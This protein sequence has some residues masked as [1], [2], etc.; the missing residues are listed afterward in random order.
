MAVIN[1]AT[2]IQIKRYNSNTWNN[3][4]FPRTAVSLLVKSV[5]DDTPFLDSGGKIQKM[6]LPD[7]L[8]GQL[9]YGGTVTADGLATLSTNA[10]TKLGITDNEIELGG[11]T[12]G[13]YSASV[14][15]GL[16]FIAS[17]Y[18]DEDDWSDTVGIEDLA[19]GD[20]VIATAS[21][22]NKID[23]T[24]AVTSVAGRTGAITLGIS[25]I[26]NLSATLDSKA[27]KSQAAFTDGVTIAG[28]LTLTNFGAGFIK[29]NAS[30]VLSVDTNNY[31]TTANAIKSVSANATNKT[32]TFT[33]ADDQPKRV[34]TFAEG[35]SN[36]TIKIT[37]N[38]SGTPAIE[39]AV[40]GLGSAAYQN[41]NAFAAASHNH[42]PSDI[43]GPAQDT[44]YNTG[45][46]MFSQGGGSPTNTPLWK[47]FESLPTVSSNYNGLMTTTDYRTLINLRSNTTTNLSAQAGDICFE[48]IV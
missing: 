13:T 10:K 5:N 46:L 2:G 19:V 18:Q 21:A 6:F 45:F 34:L 28:G 29:S 12:T 35:S 32:L 41:S 9:I 36:G 26:S 48:T 16:F 14:C 11:N 27:P 20:W 40:H 44:D 23:N 42:N 7:F 47:T 8:L 37:S 4:L 38:E 43:N 22:W 3:L 17:S 39:V 33:G 31:A 30:G 15:E 24:D 25:D 1:N